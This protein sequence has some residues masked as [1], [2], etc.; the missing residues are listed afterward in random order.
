[1]N[2]S[3]FLSRRRDRCIASILTFKDTECNSYLPEDVAEELRSVILDEVNDFCNAALDV[4]GGNVNEAFVEKL[5]E[6]QRQLA[7]LTK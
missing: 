1:M 3:N 2:Y 4:I 6:I 5:D 7:D